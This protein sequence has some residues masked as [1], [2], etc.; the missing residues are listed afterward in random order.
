MVT[1]KDGKTQICKVITGS[2]G[3]PTEGISP[4]VSIFNCEI[5]DEAFGSPYPYPFAW[6]MKSSGLAYNWD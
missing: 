2:T 6:R 1:L 5:I 4:H 3:K